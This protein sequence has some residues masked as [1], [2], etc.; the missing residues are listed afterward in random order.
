MSAIFYNLDPATITKNC[1][2]DYYYNTTVPPIILDGGRD[3]LLANFH[4]PRALKCSSVNGG[5][6]KPVSEI[7]YAVVNREFLCDCQLD[8]EHASV[9]RQL[10]SCVNS[11]SSKMHMKFTINLAFWELFKKRSPNSASNIQPQYVEEEQVF[12]VALHD[13][14]LGKLDQPVDLEKFMETMGTDGQKMTTVEE[15]EAE[16]PMQYSCDDMYCYDNSTDDYYTGASGKALQN[17]GFGIYDSNTNCPTTSRSSQF[18]SSNDVSYDSPRP[19]N[20]N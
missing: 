6:S 9:L 13:P 11:S 5:L 3:V 10:S 1:K 20:W 17:E 8:L 16:Q 19:S 2:F 14:Q 12:S 7:V 15:R 18:D 4:G